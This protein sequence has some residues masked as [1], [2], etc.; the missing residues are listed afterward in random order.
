MMDVQSQLIQNIISEI[1]GSHPDWID[2]KD[3]PRVLRL[4]S[5]AFCHG[6]LDQWSCCAE[7]FK[8]AQ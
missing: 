4:M 5:E 2:L 3:D 8:M 7:A 1:L 6:V